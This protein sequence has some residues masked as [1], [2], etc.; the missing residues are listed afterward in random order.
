MMP[1]NR[2][3]EA[4]DADVPNP[5]ARPL[6]VRWGW[7]HLVRVALGALATIAFLWTSQIG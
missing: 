4:M 6:I 2:L 7:M 1:T 5:Q 3:L